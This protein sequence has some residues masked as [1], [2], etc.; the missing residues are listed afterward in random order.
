[1]GLRIDGMD[2]TGPLG[3]DAVAKIRA[4]W[5]R[6]PVM[7][8]SDQDLTPRQHLDFAGRFG[9]LQRHTITELLHPDY[10]ELLV[11]SNRGRGGTAPI[12]NGGAYWH[13]D[14]T[15]EPEPPMGSILHG[16]IVP[17]SGGDT[18]FV[19]MTAAYAALDDETKRAL[20][21][22][23]AVHN[24][25]YRY[26]KM[27]EAGVRPP[28]SEEKMAQW[29]DVVHPVVRTHPETGEK[30]LFVNEGFTARIE[31]W[32]ESGSRAMLERLYAHCADERFVYAHRWRAGDLVLW[33]NRCTM[34]CATS[35]DLA[36]ERSMHRATIRGDRP[37]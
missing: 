15:Y 4:L 27:V 25:R 2:L 5:M 3:D 29:R 6:H 11:L 31:G 36:H 26:E 33:D 13:S 14:I 21:G 18:L 19:N 34:H 16:I 7:V 12:N 10:P 8:F 28:Q 17:P 22:V 1:M 37:V 23:S 20:D 24:Y 30:A 9:A 35:Y 32:P